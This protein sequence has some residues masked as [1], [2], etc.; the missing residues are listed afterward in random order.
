MSIAAAKGLIN[1]A[2]ASVDEAAGVMQAA[3]DFIHSA[4]ANLAEVELSLEAS[5]AYI[6]GAVGQAGGPSF[7]E[8]S[9]TAM[10][11]KNFVEKIRT[12]LDRAIYTIDEIWLPYS[13]TFTQKAGDAIDRLG[14]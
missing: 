9:D 8:I 11:L 6:A 7:F 10:N 12:D 5:I 4:K 1:A 2:S 13:Q 14:A 3:A